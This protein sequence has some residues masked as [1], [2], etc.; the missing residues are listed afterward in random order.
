N[1]R[2]SLLMRQYFT[3]AGGAAPGTKVLLKAGGEH[4]FKGL[5]PLRNRDLGNFV[6]ELAEGLQQKSVHILMF[7]ASGQQLTFAGAGKALRP[8]R[9]DLKAKDPMLPGVKPFL[10][11]ASKHPKSWS[12]FDLRPLRSGFRKLGPVAPELEKVLF[13]FDFV[14]VV[15]QGQPSHEMVAA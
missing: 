6:A 9:I 11:V 7:A 1:V 13:G 14:I 12:L 5:N 10:Q 4:A 3:A 8:A 15:P 2:R